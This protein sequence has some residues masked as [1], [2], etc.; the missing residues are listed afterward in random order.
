MSLAGVI[1]VCIG[2]VATHPLQAIR[3]V[4]RF[5]PAEPGHSLSVVLC[6][7]T[8][9]CIVCM[10]PVW[11]PLCMVTRLIFVVP[12]GA[13][14]NFVALWTGCTL[15]VVIGR[16]FFRE[17][18]RERLVEFRFRERHRF[19]TSSSV[20]PFICDCNLQHAWKLERST[21]SAPNASIARM[22]VPAVFQNP[23]QFFPE[24]HERTLVSKL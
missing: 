19:S 17:P 14:H 21:L 11:V 4:S 23:R 3:F 6:L 13:A 2:G 22:F 8:I 24:R 12:V 15:S 1:A 9:G 20:L 5:I 7:V 10:V 18:I 16:Y